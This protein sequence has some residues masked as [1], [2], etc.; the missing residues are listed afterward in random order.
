MLP[1]SI[2]ALAFSAGPTCPRTPTSAALAVRHPAAVAVLDPATKQQ[3]F[4]AAAAVLGGGGIFAYTQQQ[5]GTTGSPPPPPK[6]KA[7][8]PAAPKAKAKPTG[9]G[10]GLHSKARRVT[11][12]GH[13][14]QGN[15]PKPKP[16]EIWTPPPGWT[17]PTKPVQSWYDKGLRLE[18]PAPPPAPPP[19]AKPKNFFEQLAEAFSGGASTS[20]SSKPAAPK[21]GTGQA[22]GLHSKARRVTVGGHPKQGNMPKPKPREIW[23][24]PPGWKPPS[25]PVS[26]VSSWYDSGSRL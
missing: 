24:P 25:K 5:K 10:W 17:P 21:F 14:K 9:T 8:A 6:A 4:I 1:L 23:T 26:A 11:I 13:P 18:P 12:G 3:A 2:V 19:P 7:A 22:W 20:T 16:R 15:M